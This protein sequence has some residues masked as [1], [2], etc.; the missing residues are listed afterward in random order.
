MT[1]SRC[2]LYW[3]MGLLICLLVWCVVPCEAQ[4][5]PP[6]SAQMAEVLK[7]GG[8]ENPSAADTTRMLELWQE[9]QKPGLAQDDRVRAFRDMYLL[10]MKLRG[11]DLS[12]RPET[13]APL[14]Q[15]AAN[16]FNN[17]A[18]MDLTLPAPRG[19]P[20]GKYLHVQTFGKG[21]RHLL[22]ISDAGVDGREL[23]RTFIARNDAKYTMHVV[24][25]PGAGVA[26]PLP[27]PLTADP[28]QRVWINAIEQEL[29]Q[30]VDARKWKDVTGI[31]PS[32]GG[33]FATRLAL[34]R[35]SAFRA[36][37]VVDALVAMLM[38]SSSNPD[39]PANYEERMNRVRFRTPLQLFPVGP[40]PEAA[41]IRRLLDDQN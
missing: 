30:L 14:A 1:V 5:Q 34:D 24:T 13:M 21:S 36:V 23:F 3:A 12:S 18:R 27:W 9:A 32:I 6:T 40:M 22:L 7:Y 8:V 38:R 29:V 31:G 39:A 11:R 28:T 35:P 17:G 20:S 37:V 41:E 2:M 25:L 33:Y 26:K 16:A 4:G 10:Y 19:V 15:F